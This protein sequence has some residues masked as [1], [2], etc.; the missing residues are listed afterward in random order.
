[1]LIRIHPDLAWGAVF[2][3]PAVLVD[4]YLSLCN[5]TQLRAL[6]WVMRHA[7]EQPTAQQLADALHLRLSD[8]E[9]AVLFW[10][11]QR[12]L[13]TDVQPTVPVATPRAQQAPARVLPDAPAYKPTH[14]EILQRLREDPLLDGLCREAQEK[15]GRSLGYEGQCTLLTLHDTYG[16]PVPVIQ[17]I[18]QY[19]KEVQKTNNHYIAELGKNW[20]LEE[21]DT[22]EKAVDKV[23]V[24]RECTGL[25]KD[26]ASFAGLSATKPTAVQAEYLRTWHYDLGFSID[27]ILLAYEEMANHCNK[28]SFAY[29]NKVLRTWHD[30]GVQTPQQA[31]EENRAFRERNAAKTDDLPPAS[32]DIAQMERQLWKD[33]NEF[34]KPE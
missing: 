6:L 34:H 27:M 19:C 8:A 29:M 33:P 18:V 25:W 1:M 9:N 15:F 16:L 32:Y 13:Q 5:E 12:L 7:A 11:E 23:N 30:K 24:L 21:I 4:Q 20:A 22:I 2:S 3:V 26:L 17:I 31:A 14:A 28:L 10:Q